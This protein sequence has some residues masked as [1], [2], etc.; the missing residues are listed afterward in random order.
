[1]DALVERQPPRIPLTTLLCALAVVVALA[2]PATAETAAGDADGASAEAEV[3]R[4]K[5][6][7]ADLLKEIEA[8]RAD[9]ARSETARKA[10]EASAASAGASARSKSE[11]EAFAKD[12]YRRTKELDEARSA[13]EAAKAEQAR[14]EARVGELE[15]ENARLKSAVAAGDAE[16]VKLE[17]VKTALAERE[18]ALAELTARGDKLAEATRKAGEAED[19][20]K[21][22]RAIAAERE[23]E[24]AALRSDLERGAAK[25][26]RPAAMAPKPPPE[27]VAEEPIA[28][29]KEKGAT[30]L[31]RD[32]AAIAIAAQKEE[33]VKL[34]ARVAELKARCPVVP[35]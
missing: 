12:E 4:L 23:K 31:S 30:S 18:Q 25:A 29:K 20:L 24:I 13:N 9:L 33:I 11:Q 5:A 14:V 17:T 34:M 15:K 22:Q 1:M 3:A 7:S 6:Y 10:A 26:E 16:R 35:K 19:E 32:D 27:P 2:R 21:R 28:E 8:L